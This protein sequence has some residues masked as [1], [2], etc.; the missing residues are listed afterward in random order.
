M[1]ELPVALSFKLVSSSGV[2]KLSVTVKPTLK[3]GV[4]EYAS[5]IKVSSLLETKKPFIKYTPACTFT[6]LAKPKALELV[7]NDVPDVPTTAVAL[8]LLKV[9]FNVS[10]SVNLFVVL[11]V[12][13]FLYIT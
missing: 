6:E 10:P 4:F 2:T 7:G 11:S 3:D 1:L 9:K 8:A 13:D 12:P 5:S